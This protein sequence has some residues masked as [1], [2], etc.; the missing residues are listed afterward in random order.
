MHRTP[1]TGGVLWRGYNR[2]MDDLTTPERADETPRTLAPSTVRP[3]ARIL[4]PHQTRPGQ[5]AQPAAA[6]RPVCYVTERYGLS[7]ANP[8]TGLS[9]SRLPSALVPLPNLSTRRKRGY[10]ATS[11]RN[12]LFW[13]PRAGVRRQPLAELVA[14]LELLPDQDVQLVPVSIS[15][16]RAPSRQ[17]GWFSVLFSENWV[18]VGRFRHRLLA[19]VLEW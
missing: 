7:D 3:P 14:Q 2:R 9:R 11:M 17:S 16:G 15:V 10:F 18:V 4:D 12:S 8:R 1:P 19:L 5:P 13:I 6:R